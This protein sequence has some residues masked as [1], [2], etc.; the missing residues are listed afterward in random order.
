MEARVNEVHRVL[1]ALRSKNQL[2]FTEVGFYVE[3]PKP[4]F[5]SEKPQ[6]IALG[7]LE[8][9]GTMT[10]ETR[11]I[12]RACLIVNLARVSLVPWEGV[13]KALLPEVSESINFR[14]R[15]PDIGLRVPISRLAKQSGDATVWPEDMTDADLVLA[16][17]KIN[18]SLS[19]FSEPGSVENQNLASYPYSIS[20]ANLLLTWN[21]AREARKHRPLGKK[22]Y[23]PL[24]RIVDA[25]V[26]DSLG[27]MMNFAFTGYRVHGG[28]ELSDENE[29]VLTLFLEMGT[30]PRRQ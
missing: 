16:G 7:L 29:L 8:K 15:D 28:L 2:L 21:R 18:R 26:D 20:T 10:E 13:F 22:K 3:D 27:S 17:A 9:D 12:C 25:G 30:Q 11:I 24:G 23:W 6:L 1:T 19:D 5:G 14:E 4:S